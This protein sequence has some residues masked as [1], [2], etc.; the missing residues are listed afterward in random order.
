MRVT[1]CTKIEQ[2]SPLNVIGLPQNSKPQLFKAPLP[3]Y[4]A[5]D[6]GGEETHRA[7]RGF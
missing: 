7:R 2:F 1:L 5:S 6:H 4:S 3:D